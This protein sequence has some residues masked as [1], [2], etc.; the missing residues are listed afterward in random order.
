MNVKPLGKS[1][2]SISELSLGAM[3]LPVSQSETDAIVHA[4]IEHG[5]N[6]IDTADLYEQGENEIRVGKS[7]KHKRQDIHLSS[8]VGNRFVE[9]QEGW[10]WD[11]HPKW[12]S[13]AIENTLKRLGTDYLDLYQLHGGTNEDDWDGIIDSMNR[14]KERGLIREYGISSIRPNVIYPYF[15]KSDAVSVMMQYSGLDRRAEMV[16]PFLDEHSI[17]LLVR[18]GQAKGLLTDQALDKLKKV[19]AY[20]TYEEVEL[21]RAV[22]NMTEQFSSLGA[23]SLHHILKQPTVSSVVIGSSSKAQLEDTVSNY[24]QQVSADEIQLFTSFTK[25]ENY[26]EHVD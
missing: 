1:S 20:G 5:I 16:F 4:A 6:W 10:S 2:L 3:S 18:G 15:E 9:G 14:L 19:K 13:V 7:I 21:K 26:K 11:P 22:T 8:K 12:I 24:H 23:V 25:Q 17:G